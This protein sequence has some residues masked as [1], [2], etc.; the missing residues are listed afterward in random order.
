M[1]LNYRKFGEGPALIILH[2][3]YGASDNWVSIARELA[4]NFEVFIPD[5]RNHG[6]SPHT[7]EHN[8]EFLREDLYS[9]MEK[10][11]IKKATLL[12]HSMGG[13][14]AMFF[15]TQYPEKI[16]NLI[17]VDISPRSYVDK[18]QSVPHT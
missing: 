13:K 1:E 17:V 7:E 9:F 11:S 4:A 6:D 10:H 3:L 12:G 2:G 15:A 8:Y 18:D 14:A 16:E 5:Q